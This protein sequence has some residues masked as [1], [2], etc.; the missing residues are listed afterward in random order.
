MKPL[1]SYLN[2]EN[3]Q[4][5]RKEIARGAFP[6][7]SFEQAMQFLLTDGILP[8]GGSP[9]IS[10]LHLEDWIRSIHEIQTLSYST[11]ELKNKT[12]EIIENVLRGKTVRLIKHGRP[13]AEIKKLTG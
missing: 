12:G 9:A 2:D 1:S 6:G 8:V 10:F 3:I 4:G 11:T 7:V 13:I 5:L